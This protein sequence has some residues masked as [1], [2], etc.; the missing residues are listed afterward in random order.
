[1]TTEQLIKRCIDKDHGAWGEF[2]KRYQGLVTRGVRYKLKKLN[3]NLPNSEFRDIV[4][5]IF[6]YIWEK[7]KLS[8]IRDVSCIRAWLAMI[9]V[10][11][12]FNY[13]KSK[14]FRME[15][16]ARSLDED[17]SEDKPGRTLKSI[18]PSTKLDNSKSIESN[19]I[20][21]ALEKGISKL[22]HKQ[23]LALKLSLYDGRTQKEISRIMNEP[24]NTIA[25]HIKRGKEYLRKGLSD[26][27]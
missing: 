12:T 9:S 20:R 23:Q 18:L 2:V 8:G 15:R 16:N 11:R 3:I 1:M 22:S 6:L 14:T 4:Q 25:S 19:E 5:E 13:C 24:E 27:L 17:L 26:F 7:D 10:N 21:K